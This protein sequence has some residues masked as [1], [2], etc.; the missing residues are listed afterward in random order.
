MALGWIDDNVL[1]FFLLNLHYMLLWKFTIHAIG[2][3]SILLVGRSKRWYFSP[4]D[5]R[6]CTGKPDAMWSR[7]C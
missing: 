6:L 2:Q 3:S 1:E 4:L 7:S 5:G